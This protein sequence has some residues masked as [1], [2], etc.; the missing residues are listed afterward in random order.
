ML[1]QPPPPWRHAATRFFCSLP[2]SRNIN[3]DHFT[4]GHRPE[5]FAG[6]QMQNRLIKFLPLAARKGTPRDM[7]LRAQ[8][9]STLEHLRALLIRHATNSL[10]FN[11]KR[12]EA[13]WMT[14]RWMMRDRVFHCHASSR[15]Y[16]WRVH[17]W[18]LFRCATGS[19]IQSS[20]K[21][22]RA[23]WVFIVYEETMW[24]ANIGQLF[25]GLVEKFVFRT[26]DHLSKLELA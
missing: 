19:G 3:Y 12:F 9:P 20:W 15:V 1:A 26:W 7:A 11:R 18:A 22:A 25:F 24:F 5:V 17:F 4:K 10:A 16:A 2:P 6:Y 21:V 13:P 8:Y 14:R 23:A